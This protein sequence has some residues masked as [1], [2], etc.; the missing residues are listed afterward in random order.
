MNNCAFDIG[1]EIFLNVEGINEDAKKKLN[2]SGLRLFDELK[3]KNP[4]IKSIK[5]AINN[6]ANVN[7]LNENGDSVLYMAIRSIIKRT[8]LKPGS[9]PVAITDELIYGYIQQYPNVNLDIVEL[10]LD[11]G[12]DA[13]FTNET[14][15]ECTSCLWAALFV[16]KA[17]LIELLLSHGA[18]PNRKDKSG[19]SILYWAHFEQQYRRVNNYPL[20]EKEMEEIINL[21]I[22]YGGL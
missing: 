2:D 17:R 18:N 3:K 15:E 13:D 12:A 22:K 5:D 10:L 11:N 6:G 7:A 14:E 1:I 20:V 21:I 9:D 8:M 19:D 16:C 4:N